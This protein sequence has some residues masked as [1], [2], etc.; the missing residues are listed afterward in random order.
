MA[1]GLPHFE[2]TDPL[3]E[4]ISALEEHGALVIDGLLDRGTVERMNAELDPH[5][6]RAPSEREFLNPALAWFFGKRTRHVTAV[7]SKSA[8]FAAEVLCHPTLLG[9]SDAVLGPS[10]ARYQ[11]NLAHVLDR[12]PGVECGSPISVQSLS[13]G[14]PAFFHAGKPSRK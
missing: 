6:E 14:Y 9:V 2:S 11:L 5:V 8:T 13:N 4:I 3:P 1:R 7:A 10:C 12:G